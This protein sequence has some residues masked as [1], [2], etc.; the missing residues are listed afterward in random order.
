MTDY[1]KIDP[2]ETT[3]G[4]EILLNGDW[5]RA[6]SVYHLS[7]GTVVVIWPQGGRMSGPAHH[8]NVRRAVQAA[9][10]LAGRCAEHRA[11]MA[12]NCPVCGT[13]AN[14]PNTVHG[15]V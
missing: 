15:Q 4:D 12:D 11:Y 14:I 10:V 6:K 2:R 7:G 1:V 13:A 5:H 8:L 9:P 3:A